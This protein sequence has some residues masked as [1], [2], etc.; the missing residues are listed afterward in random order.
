MKGADPWESYNSAMNGASDFLKQNASL[1][2]ITHTLALL[3]TAMVCSALFGIA[4]ALVAAAKTR[5][6]P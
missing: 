5:H 6:E 3:I 2:T 1:T 4:D